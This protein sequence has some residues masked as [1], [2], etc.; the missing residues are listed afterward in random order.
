MK[1]LHYKNSLMFSE[2]IGCSAMEFKFKG[3]FI[4]ESNL[5]DDWYVLTSKNK[6]LC[7]SLTGEQNVSEL[8]T[9]QGDFII[10]GTKIIT[11]DLEEIS[12]TYEK[13]DIDT[14]GRSKE[15]FEGGGNYYSDYDT[16]HEA[17][18]TIDEID[19]YKNNLYTKQDEFFYENGENYFGEY[20]QHS[21]GQA[22]T[23]SV[24][25]ADSVNIYR[26]TQNNKLLKPKPK[27]L[28]RITVKDEIDPLRDQGE[29]YNV[30]THQQAD[31]L[32]S[33]G[34]SAGGGGGGTY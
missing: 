14:F 33:K 8:F 12:C 10:I 9:F 31:T 32:G 5:S 2:V 7:I 11:K 16:I 3:K 34:T 27:R 17:I 29:K 4:G 30:E 23:E 15:T 28:K 21:N 25:N 24:H 19:I 20:H 18:D 26:K 6:I 1:L 22:M 13:L